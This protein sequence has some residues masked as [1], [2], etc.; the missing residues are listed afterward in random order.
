MAKRV[1]KPIFLRDDDYPS[2]LRS[3]DV[4]KVADALKNPLAFLPIT[5]VD[6]GFAF[7]E[8]SEKK[9]IS[10]ANLQTVQTNCAAFMRCL[11]EELVKR[12]PFNTKVIEKIRHFNPTNVL[13]AIAPKFTDLPFE[14]TSNILISSF[15]FL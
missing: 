10:F 5:E 12:L 6:F 13:S 14:L 9:T 2:V 4:K 11:C 7:K 15:C 1:I 8:L 3:E